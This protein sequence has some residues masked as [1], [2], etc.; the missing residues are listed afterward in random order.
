MLA[1][2]D[3]VPDATPEPPVELLHLTAVTATLSPATP[4]IAMVE[5]VVERIVNPGDLICKEGGVVSPAP[6]GGVG[7]GGVDRRRCWRWRCG[8]GWGRAAAHCCRR[9]RECRR[10]RH[11]STRWTACSRG[12][13]PRR[14]DRSG[15]ARAHVRLHAR[16]PKT[17]PRRRRCATAHRRPG[18]D[19][20]RWF[21]SSAER[22]RRYAPAFPP[23]HRRDSRRRARRGRTGCPAFVRPPAVL[24]ATE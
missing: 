20:R 10:C 16:P 1:D 17:D 11:R 8:R 9:G 19:R 21:P 22:D 5:A 24:P 23:R 7:V 13:S 12:T 6:D 18:A 14:D 3:A 4:L 15:P 2:Q